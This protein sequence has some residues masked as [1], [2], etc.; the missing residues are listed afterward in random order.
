MGVEVR[1]IE[2]VPELAAEA[3]AGPL[4]CAP[5]WIGIAGQDAGLG[6]RELG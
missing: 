5:S 1:S 4:G 3:L 6:W 2:I